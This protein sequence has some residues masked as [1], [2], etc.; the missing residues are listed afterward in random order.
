MTG[1]TN[2]EPSKE[3]SNK[4]LHDMFISLMLPQYK[5]REEV[6]N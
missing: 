1:F 5:T 2:L 6:L 3:Y 4:E